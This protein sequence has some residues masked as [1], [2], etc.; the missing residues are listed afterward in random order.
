MEQ[1]T[2]PSFSFINVSDLNTSEKY[3]S[4]ILSTI[5][6]LNTFKSC[7][8]KAF[9][10]GLFD[11]VEEET[12]KTIIWE[13]KRLLALYKTQMKKIIEKTGFDT[14]KAIE[15]FTKLMPDVKV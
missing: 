3:A 12:S 8:E 7:E 14:E 5:V 15:D 9:A 2:K 11:E 6:S 4:H 10:E 1:D 13:I